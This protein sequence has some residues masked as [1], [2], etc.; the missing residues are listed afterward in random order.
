MPASSAASPGPRAFAPFPNHPFAAASTPTKFEP[1][2]AR[3]R[4]CERIHSLS[5]AR[6]ILTAFTASTTFHF[7]DF[8]CGSIRRTACIV[9]VEA[10]ETRR[11]AVT[12]WT[13][14]RRALSGRTP[15]CVQKVPSSDATSALTIQSSGSAR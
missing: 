2:G 4:Y 12:F 11:P 14:A 8:G 3:F 7:S 10:P 9:S 13:A 15:Q 6:S 1:K 5:R